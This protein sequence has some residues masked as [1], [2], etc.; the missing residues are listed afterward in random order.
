MASIP[1]PDGPGFYFPGARITYY[2]AV[3]T[4]EFPLWTATLT[5]GGIPESGQVLTSLSYARLE[6]DV[7]DW[8]EWNEWGEL[9]GWVRDPPSYDQV[10]GDDD[11]E[12]ADGEDGGGEGWSLTYDCRWPPDVNDALQRYWAATKTIDQTSATIEETSAALGEMLCTIHDGLQAGKADVAALVC[13]P[14]DEAEEIISAYGELEYY[15]KAG[16]TME[17][18][19]ASRE[20]RKRRKAES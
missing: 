16:R 9:N 19:R 3:V 13:L 12:T 15:R 5:G 20:Q 2:R 17:D 11:D 10:D 7:S 4:R 8:L 18:W 14:A 6:G 1:R